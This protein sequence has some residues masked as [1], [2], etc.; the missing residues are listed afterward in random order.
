MRAVVDTNVVLVTN[1]AHEDVSPECVLVCIDRLEALMKRGTVVIDDAYRIL[2]EYQ[3]KTT[4]M[5]NK[6]VGDVFVLWLLKNS[7][8]RRHVEAVPLQEQAPDQFAQFPDADLHDDIDPPDRKFLAVAAAHPDQPPV[9]QAT[10]C[11]WLDWWPRLAATGVT[12]DFLCDAEVCRYYTRKFPDRP[13]PERPRKLR[14][15]R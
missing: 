4:P 6:R 14:T 7:A 3:H 12:V 13:L 15:I 1:D 2:G 9:W 10:D 11:K 8:N 5:K